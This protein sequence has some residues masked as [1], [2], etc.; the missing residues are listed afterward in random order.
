MQYFESIDGAALQGA[1]L[2]PGSFDGLHRG[3]RRLLDRMLEAAARAG[4]PPA[5]LTFFP[6]PRAVLRPPGEPAAIRYLMPLE[7]RLALLRTLPLEALILQPFDAAFS[8]IGAAEFLRMLQTRLGLRGLW[9]GPS[10]AVGCRREGDVAY[11][12]GQSGAF[13]FALHVVPPLEHRGRPVSSSWIRE[14]LAQ[15]D[16]RL[17]ADLLGR[18]FTLSGTVV[19]GAGRGRCLGMPTANIALRPEIVIPAYGVYATRAETA[20]ARHPAVTSVGLRPTFVNASV[21]AA[22]VETHLLDFDGDLYGSDLRV[23][24][25]ERLREERKFADADSL[26]RQMAS[27]AARARGLLREET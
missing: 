25:V 5:V 6:H 3:H 2:A 7:E 23:E 20:G 10:F 17:A 16:L 21:H 27:D 24:F 12:T 22:T 11:L 9:C 15:G 1:Y 14:A 13:G 19:H 4:A 8:R 18:R 26:R